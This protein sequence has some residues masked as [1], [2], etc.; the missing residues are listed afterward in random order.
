MGVI[1]NK[2]GTFNNIPNS[3][4]S[5]NKNPTHEHCALHRQ[6]TTSVETKVGE[7]KKYSQLIL[8]Y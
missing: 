8:C 1:H 4:Q 3:S 2:I 5:L 6:D 7:R